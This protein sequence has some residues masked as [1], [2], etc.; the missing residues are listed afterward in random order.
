[1]MRVKC[2]EVS[3]KFFKKLFEA[4]RCQVIKS[5]IIL[6]RAVVPV[7]RAK[8]ITSELQVWYCPIHSGELE[9]SDCTLLDLD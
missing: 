8:I 5:A 6:A 4:L 2:R 3:V 1:M 9:L 7:W